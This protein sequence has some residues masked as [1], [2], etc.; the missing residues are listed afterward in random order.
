MKL[1]NAAVRNAGDAMQASLR[2]AW[3]CALLIAWLVAAVVPSVAAAAEEAAAT[4][5]GESAEAERILKCM[6]DNLPERMRMREFELST[7]E[8]GASQPGR[9][10]R[11]R[12]ALLREDGR[13]HVN[14][15]VASPGDLAGTSYLWRELESR[16]ETFVYIPA[17]QRVRRVVGSGAES[18][19]F[20]S[21]FSL[22]DLQQV[23]GAF[24][25]GTAELLGEGEFNGRATWRM[26]FVP[27]ADEPTE[28]THVESQ[29][30]QALCVTLQSLF[31][32]ERGPVKRFE[33]DV[34]TLVRIEHIAYA[35]SAEMA[36]LRRGR[37]STVRLTEL[38]LP[39]QLPRRLFE[40]RGFHYG[41]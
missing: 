38:E 25:S 26:R 37:S 20:D 16:D 8:K 21:E 9:V 17:L 28:Y 13:G 35:E 12:M 30:D 29:I 7:I 4:P 41:N 2:A 19:V 27:D 33:A 40:P 22:R 11:G 34:D 14:V 32:D 5:H 6:R 15:R 39:E 10:I 3:R 31:N 23:Q 36:N 1:G 24:S 18:G